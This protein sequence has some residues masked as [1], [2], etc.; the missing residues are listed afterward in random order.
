MPQKLR[1][2]YIVGK[3]FYYLFIYFKFALISI[4]YETILSFVLVAMTKQSFVFV[5]DGGKSWIS[6]W[7]TANAVIL[8][9]TTCLPAYTVIN[10]SVSRGQL[11]EKQR[12]ER[13]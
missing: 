12:S 3:N 7:A 8:V 6:R 5:A 4:L 13:H 11:E 1:L 9:A 10:S 2:H